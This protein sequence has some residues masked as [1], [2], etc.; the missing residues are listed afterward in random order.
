MF[1]VSVC[2]YAGVLVYA[3]FWKCDPKSASYVETDDQLFPFYVLQTVGNYRGIPGLFVAGVFGAALSSLSVILNSTAGVI[4]EDI[5]RGCFKRQP[6]ERVSY[7]I[8]KGSILVLGALSI[9]L[10]LI[11]ERLG[12]ILEVA[13]SLSA[14]AAGTTFGVFSLGMLIPWSNNIGA[15]CGAIAGALISAWIAIGTQVA[16]AYGLVHPHKLIT[17]IS[18]CDATLL[19]VT[20]NESP[21]YPDESNV[22]PLYRL[23]FDWINPIGILTVLIVGSIA[24]FISGPRDLRYIDPVLISPILHR[25]LPRECFENANRQSLEPENS[26]LFILK[27]GQSNA[28]QKS[29][30]VRVK[31]NYYSS[32]K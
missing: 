11:V 25:F 6:S 27:V 23:S 8:V 13:T 14:I 20:S 31:R 4:L 17:S 15:I 29:T 18:Q 7:Y 2:C 12:G 24:S 28:E 21:I 32:A 10:M 5:C 22:F 16:F 30:Q 1:F 26:E 19:N 3:A 9:I